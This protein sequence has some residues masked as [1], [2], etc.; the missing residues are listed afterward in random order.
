AKVRLA[1]AD[2]DQNTHDDIVAAAT[3]GHSTIY[4]SD[5]AGG[6]ERPIRFSATGTNPPRIAI[7][8]LG[9]DSPPDI[10][11]GSN[12]EGQP[13]S[14]TD[15]SAIYFNQ[16]GGSFT[17]PTQLG[18]P[19]D[20]ITHVATGSDGG[21]RR[22]IAAARTTG[23]VFTIIVYTYQVTSGIPLPSIIDCSTPGAA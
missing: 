8:H 12:G 16:G 3:P 20:N 6:L 15:T 9:D 22:Y 5:Q 4:A 19:G 13:T 14:V 10:V 1:V 11:V 2:I 21:S 7:G 18:Q 17:N 23:S